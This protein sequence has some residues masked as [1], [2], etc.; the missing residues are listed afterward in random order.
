MMKLLLAYR[1]DVFAN[2][3]SCLYL[4]L[5]HRHIKKQKKKRMYNFSLSSPFY[6]YAEMEIFKAGCFI[7]LLMS[8]AGI[9]V[10]KLM[11]LYFTDFFSQLFLL[12]K[13]LSTNNFRHA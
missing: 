8:F 3:Q 4:L 9:Y 2:L 13:G 1:E 10:T 5:C 6:A 7:V 12:S 11:Y